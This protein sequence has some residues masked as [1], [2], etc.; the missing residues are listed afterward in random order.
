MTRLLRG[1]TCSRARLDLVALGIGALPMLLGPAAIVSG[2]ASAL[3]E[4]DRISR[5][6]VIGACLGLASVII[7]GWWFGGWF[8]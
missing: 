2:I 4:H 7:T 8:R 6:A 1:T 5:V 3:P